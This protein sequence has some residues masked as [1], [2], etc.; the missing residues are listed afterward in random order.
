MASY[1][2]TWPYA[3]FLFVPKRQKNKKIR[4]IGK[5][6]NDKFLKCRPKGLIRPLKGLIRPLKRLIR[7]F[8]GLIRPAGLRFFMQ[9]G[10]VAGQEAKNSC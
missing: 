1:R 7:P 10:L 8:K 5:H 9:A 6:E 4:K 2:V 3:N